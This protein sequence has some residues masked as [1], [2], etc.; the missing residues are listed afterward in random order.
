MKGI[1]KLKQLC[2]RPLKLTRRQI[3]SGLIVFLLILVFSFVV[4]VASRKSLEYGHLIKE[5]ASK[6]WSGTKESSY[7]LKIVDKFYDE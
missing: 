6:T 4:F 2:W 5:K 1:S 3:A 7:I